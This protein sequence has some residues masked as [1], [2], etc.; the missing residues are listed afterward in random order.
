[1]AGRWWDRLRISAP[2][3]VASMRPAQ[4]SPVWLLEAGEANVP[5][6]VGPCTAVGEYVAA[7]P[8]RVWQRLAAVGRQ[9]REALVGLPGWTVVGPADAGSAITALRAANG[10]DIGQTRERACSASTGS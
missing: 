4:A 8:D 3:L 5:G 9:T 1:M 10:Q 6:W 2:D 7:G